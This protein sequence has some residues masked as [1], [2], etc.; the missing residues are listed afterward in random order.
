MDTIEK[1]GRYTLV[2]QV[3]FGGVAYAIAVAY[4]GVEAYAVAFALVVA[5][6]VAVAVNLMAIASQNTIGVAVS[7]SSLAMVLA[8]FCI[9]GSSIV[10]AVIFSFIGLVCALLAA[11]LA[12]HEGL[13]R[14]E[15]LFL[16]FLN[17]L[18]VVGPSWSILGKWTW[19]RKA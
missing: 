14:G 18:P 19:R 2:R 15:S 4:R 13:T 6:L 10:F 1:W 12:R 16:V 9:I 5:G 17:V 7:L 3:L 8:G 11:M